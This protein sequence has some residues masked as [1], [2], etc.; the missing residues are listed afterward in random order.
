VV[1]LHEGR[2]WVASEPG[3]GSTFSFTLP[4]YSL[5]KL[6]APVIA[7]EGHLRS[8]FVLVR[9]DLA[10]MTNP[11]RGNWREIWQQ[12]LDVLRRCVYLDKDLVLPPMGVAG[13]TETFYV[14]ASTHMQRSAIMT[15]RIREQ[16]ERMVDLKTRGTLTVTTAPVEFDA[17]DASAKLE[18]QI[19]AVAGRVTEMI[20]ANMER[21]QRT[22]GGN[23]GKYTN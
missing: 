12:C 23:S 22:I 20:I 13:A 16:L 2:I 4:V 11:P 7:Y 3:Q 9:V 10:P 14:V 8:S 21:K 19:E 1:R 18:Q 5:P 15:T 17:V 6:L